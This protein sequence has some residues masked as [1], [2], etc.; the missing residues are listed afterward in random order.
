[1]QT[2]ERHVARSITKAKGAVSTIDAQFALALR[3]PV[4]VGKSAGA[5][6]AHYAANPPSEPA[7]AVRA[8]RRELATK[9]REAEADLREAERVLR[10]YERVAKFLRNEGRVEDCPPEL[11]AAALAL[12]ADALAGGGSAAEVAERLSE[13][14]AHGRSKLWA[15]KQNHRSIVG[16]AVVA[17]KAQSLKLMASYE[18]FEALAG[19][20]VMLERLRSAQRRRKD[21]FVKAQRAANR[22]AR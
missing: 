11:R 14:V 20:E 10:G 4:P 16:A 6:L 1:M 15:A 22:S 18:G 17:A 2:L 21:A 5:L 12:K 19:N 9:L 13:A 7:V 3:P 8:I